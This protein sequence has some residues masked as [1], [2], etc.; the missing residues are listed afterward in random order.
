MHIGGHF[1][2]KAL[3]NEGFILFRLVYYIKYDIVLNI[4][5]SNVV[6]EDKISKRWE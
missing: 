3:L 5:I 4:Y 2:Y 1:D 6:E